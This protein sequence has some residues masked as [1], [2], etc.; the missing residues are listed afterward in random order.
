MA[1]INDRVQIF[2]VCLF[3]CLSLLLLKIIFQ[4]N[5]NL[6]ELL[7]CWLHHFFSIIG[8]SIELRMTNGKE[9]IVYTQ[10]GEHTINGPSNDQ[11]I[12]RISN[13]L[14]ILH[15]TPFNI[16]WLWHNV[17]F[18]VHCYY[19]I[20]PAPTVEKQFLSN[21][22]NSAVQAILCCL[23]SIYSASDL[24]FL[25]ILLARQLVY[26]VKNTQ[27]HQNSRTH[28]FTFT[29]FAMRSRVFVIHFNVIVMVTQRWMDFFNFVATI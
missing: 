17:A 8:N 27:T 22:P 9:A 14:F 7:L 2:F 19:T 12:D 24:F 23:L 25:Y 6:I 11:W 3:V 21:V 13:F 5:S 29:Q 16:P 1:I 18:G 4:F 28:S 15:W 10:E 26:R 20:P